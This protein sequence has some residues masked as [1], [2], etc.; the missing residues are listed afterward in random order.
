MSIMFGVCLGF[1][2]GVICEDYNKEDTDGNDNTV[3]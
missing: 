2:I 3:R 1:L